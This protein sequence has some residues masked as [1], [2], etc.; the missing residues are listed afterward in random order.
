MFQGSA[1]GPL[2]FTVFANDMALFS[3]GASVVQYADDTQV[4]ITGKK[5][6]LPA[7]ISRMELSLASLAEWFRANALK[8]NA[9]KTQLIAFGNHQNLRNLP[10]F[11]VT[12]CDASLEP[13]SEVQNLGVTFDK[14]LSWDSHVATISRR[15]LGTLAGLSHARHHLPSGIITTLV[16]SLV[17]SQVR[18]CI[19]VY[20]NT[21]QKN[22]N[23]IQKILNYGAKVIFGRRKFD[24]SSDLREK[25]QW[26]PARELE[27]LGTLCLAHKVMRRG[28]PDSLAGVF[29]TNSTL[30]ER[31]TRQ[32]EL[33]HVPP[34]RTNDGERRFCSRA[35]AA[36]NRLPDSITERNVRAF[37]RALKRHLLDRKT[38]T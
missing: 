21:S 20:G 18:Y 14:T 17:L 2:L 27:E 19:S 3:S 22:L 30:R 37:P 9:S 26:L 36:Y 11:K 5:S 15:C 24:P 29:V 16:T 35:P 34:W 31:N 38:P 8:V 12:F 13:C 4:L 1:L 25:L 10:N 28:E 6:D 32:D 33:L 7:L 23:K